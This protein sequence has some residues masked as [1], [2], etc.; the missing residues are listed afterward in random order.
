M[1]RIRALTRLRVLAGIVGFASVAVL[2]SWGSAQAALTWSSAASIERGFISCATE[3]SCISVSRGGL[4]VYEAGRGVFS[5]TFSGGTWSA[6]TPVEPEGEF[7]ESRIY[8]ASCAS[9]TFCAAVGENHAHGNSAP[10]AYTFDGTSWHSWEHFEPRFEEGERRLDQVSCVSA[11]FCVAAGI[12]GY[13]SIFDGTGWSKLQ[14]LGS[15]F[16]GTVSCASESFCVATTAS[17]MGTE[18]KPKI[19]MF[20]GS[21]WTSAKVPAKMLWASCASAQWCVA[22]GGKNKTGTVDTAVFNGVKWKR[23]TAGEVFPAVLEGNEESL[24]C[25]SSSLCVATNA[26]GQLNTLVTSGKRHKWQTPTHQE[27]TNDGLT[28]LSCPTAAFCATETEE[29]EVLF[30]TD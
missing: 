13:V 15:G 1:L 9:P 10:Q 8:A 30:G 14:R 25:P 4:H 6:P 18:R 2:G 16:L 19:W 27:A 23:L 24:S 29:G 26:V 22:I 21:S 7:Q 3:S 11:S 28:S 17:T 5:R 12:D 20:N